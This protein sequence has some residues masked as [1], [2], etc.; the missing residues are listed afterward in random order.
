MAWSATLINSIDQIKKD[1][2]IR[3]N[4]DA[5]IPVSSTSGTIDNGDQQAAHQPSIYYQQLVDNQGQ[6]PTPNDILNA[7]DV[8]EGY[9]KGCNKAETQSLTVLYISDDDA[10]KID[11]FKGF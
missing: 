8:M 2:E 4:R 11:T 10:Y 3:F 7:L 6:S 9:I 5:A 1:Y